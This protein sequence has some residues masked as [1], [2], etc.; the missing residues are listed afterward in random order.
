[1]VFLHVDQSAWRGTLVNSLLR[2][3][4]LLHRHR[5]ERVKRKNGSFDRS[6]FGKFFS[7]RGSRSASSISIAHRSRSEE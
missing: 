5:S 1:M 3:Y 4:G 7:I 2:F 6:W